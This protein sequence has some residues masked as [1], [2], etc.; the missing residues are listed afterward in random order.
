MKVAVLPM[1]AVRGIRPNS[2]FEK[3]HPRPPRGGSGRKTARAES[4]TSPRRQ[5]AQETGALDGLGQLAL[6]LLAYRVMREGT[7]LPRS[8][9]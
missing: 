2:G 9:I 7:I 6:L 1:A 5:K 4:L 3:P 8:E